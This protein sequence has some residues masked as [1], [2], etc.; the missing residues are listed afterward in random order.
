MSD[1]PG[2]QLFLPLSQTISLPI[3]QL[4]LLISQFTAL[5]IAILFKNYCSRERCSPK[6][7]HLISILIGILI[8]FFMI[9]VYQTF[10]L[11]AIS[12]I[13][14]AILKVKQFSN[15]SHHVTLLFS[16]SVLASAHLKRLFEIETDNIDCRVA[17]RVSVYPVHTGSVYPVPFRV[18]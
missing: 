18:R 17:N 8:L 14:L 13:I 10:Q 6:T 7:R 5:P 16:M 15:V 1:Y 4:N 11:F 12:T 3:D 9:G 2:C